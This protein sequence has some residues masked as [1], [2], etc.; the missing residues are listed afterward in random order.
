MRR[1]FESF[2]SLLGGV[3]VV[4]AAK[5]FD[6]DEQLTAHSL[7]SWANEGSHAVHDDIYMAPSDTED[8]F[9]LDVF[10]RIFDNLNHSGH[11][12]LMMGTDFKEPPAVAPAPTAGEA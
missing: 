12:K 2:S 5:G 10:R 8:A 6:G 1:I 7:L 11:Y 4:Q 3:D 9:Y